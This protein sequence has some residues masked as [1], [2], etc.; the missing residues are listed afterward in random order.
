[1]KHIY[2]LLFLTLTVLSLAGCIEN[3]EEYFINPDGSGKVVYE[4]SLQQ[5]DFGMGKQK[6]PDEKAKDMVRAEL[7]NAAGVDAWRDIHYESDG[8]DKVLFRGTAYFRDLSKLKFYNAGTSVSLYNQMVLSKAGSTL[9]LEIK[10]A[11]KDARSEKDAATTGELTQ[12][13]INQKIADSMQQYEKSKLMFAATLSAMKIRRILHLPG[14]VSMTSNLERNEDGALVHEFLGSDLMAIMDSMMTDEE[15]LRAEITAGKDVMKDGPG[16]DDRLNEKLFGEQGPIK[17]VCVNAQEPS[18]NF[19]EEVAQAREDARDTF[20]ELSVVSKQ[21]VDISQAKDFRVGGVRIVAESSMEN[22]VRPFNWDKGYVISMIGVLPETAINATGGK[23]VSAETDNGEDILPERD[24]DRKISFP[25]LGNDNKTVV[26]EVNMSLPSEQAKGIKEVAGVVEYVVASATRTV[27]L[28]ISH[29]ATGVKGSEFGAEIK[30]LAEDSWQPGKQTMEL[31]V[32]LNKDRV[33]SVTITDSAGSAIQVS[34]GYS[35]MGDV[36]TY[37]Y[38]A[39]E[40][41]FP[42][43][44]SIILEVYEDLKTVE[45]PFKVT[46]I[47]FLGKPLN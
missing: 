9:T 1:M 43:S 34:S 8:E 45:L 37:A 30:T 23:L 36:T 2:S 29:F 24:W 42:E 11:K 19:E 4:S 13:E 7:E 15:W 16:G 22:G 35:A 26:F 39:K 40:G 12:Q 14:E 20:K 25:R 41:N 33:K 6:S 32:D 27:D 28:Q 38:T 17:A 5:M 44:G 18:F 3:S 31:K 46:D 10:S 21:S 47:S